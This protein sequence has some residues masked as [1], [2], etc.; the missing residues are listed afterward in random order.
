[1]NNCLFYALYK[2]YKCGGFIV[3]RKSKYGN[4][5]HVMWSK[6]LIEFEHYVPL[7]LPLKYPWISKVLFR[8]RVKKEGNDRNN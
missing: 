2:F 5:S 8:G 7:K 6:N 4:W 1:M 3:I